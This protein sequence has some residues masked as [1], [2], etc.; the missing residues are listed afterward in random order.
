MRDNTI[1]EIARLGV[2]GWHART[3]AADGGPSHNLFIPCPVA[4]MEDLHRDAA[5]IKWVE[6]GIAP[7]HIHMNYVLVS[8]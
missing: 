4:V 7:F 3:A 1:N 5:Q 2:S 8:S 6:A